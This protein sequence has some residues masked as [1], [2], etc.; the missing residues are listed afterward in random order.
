[1]GKDAP[2]APDPKETGAA[3]TGTN[4]GTAIAN[5]MMGFVDQKTP[6]GKL[7]YEQTGDYKY[8]D[9]YTGE[10]YKIPTFSATQKLT[11][12]QQAINQTNLATQ[13]NLATLAKDQ[14]S[15]LSDLLSSPFSLDSAPDAASIDNLQNPAYD[16]F[17]DAPNLATSF[18]DAGQIK[19]TIDNAG[20]ITKSYGANDFSADRTKVEQALMARM[21]PYLDKQKES[22]ESRLANQGVRLGSNA[23][24]S[25]QDDF[26]RQINDATLANII[27]AG[28]EQSRMVAMDRDR[29]TFQN[30]AQQQQYS[31]NANDANF[32]NTAQQQRYGQLLGR[33]TFGNSAAQQNFG[34]TNEV[35]T[36]NNAI[37]TQQFN[38]Q[39]TKMNMQNR[40][41][42]QA[43]D[44]SFAERNQPINEISA[45]LGG[46]QVK[47]PTWA[48]ADT[49]QI[50]TTDY[51][52]II[53]QDF[54]NRMALYQQ[55]QASLGGLLGGIGSMF[56]S[57]SDRRAKKDVRPAGRLMGHKLHEYR[58][59]GEP[60]SAPK[61]I[62]VMAQEVEK[63]R[64]DAVA[65]GPDGLKRVQ[66][67]KLF[68]RKA[69]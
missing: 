10:K 40:L 18:D 2:D 26:G 29:A 33:A 5:T 4:V 12:K 68:A 11:P 53:N 32:G 25:A 36:R 24:G 35:T 38:D 8:K 31:Q 60:E 19:D 3:Q 42:Q 14:S 55:Q 50:P 56:G 30:S 63:T 49:A 66:Y 59:K 65:T 22:L 69:A 39:I 16:Q 46:T 57:L 34:N 51:A 61:T 6:W 62:G 15:R 17:G 20:A 48:N 9:P 45:L 43:I 54:Q 28:D 47:D 67:G 44:E 13:K 52:G 7:K 23:Y 21:Q 64:P 1:M 37:D 41:R 27:A 58:Y